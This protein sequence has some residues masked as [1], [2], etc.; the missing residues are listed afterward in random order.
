MKKFLVL[1]FAAVFIIGMQVAA[2]QAVPGEA[3]IDSTDLGQF[4]YSTDNNISIVS[5]NITEANLTT[6]MSTY[7]WAGLVGTVTGDIVLG[8]GADNVLYNWSAEGNVVYATTL[9]SPNWTGIVAQTVSGLEANFPWLDSGSDS[10]EET[11]SG[12][13]TLPS[14]IFTGIDT[15]RAQTFDEGSTPTWN[16]FAL[17][18]GSNTIFAGQVNPTGANDYRGETVNYQMIVPEDGTE[19]DNTPTT[20]NLWVELI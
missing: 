11:F 14:G 18:D 3:D 12:S 1:M 2:A 8:T 20:Y 4:E 17:T 9:S 5:G 19:G 6:R 15:I 16:T 10:A 13:V 7:R